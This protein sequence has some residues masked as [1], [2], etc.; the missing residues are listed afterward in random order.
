M[1]EFDSPPSPRP[2]RHIGQFC[3]PIFNAQQSN[4]G[5]QQNMGIGRWNR[6]ELGLEHDLAVLVALNQGSATD[7]WNV[8]PPTLSDLGLNSALAR[9]ARG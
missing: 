3:D 4:A 8:F 6:V 1:V 2:L 9:C 7:V 5:R